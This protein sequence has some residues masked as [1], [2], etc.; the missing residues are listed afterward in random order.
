MSG[1]ATGRPHNPGYQATE[2]TGQ[3]QAACSRQAR[4]P[5][6][7][8][9]ACRQ[10]G[11][12]GFSRSMP[13]FPQNATGRVWECRIL[14]EKRH[15]A[16]S[17]SAPR[18]VFCCC[19]RDVVAFFTKDGIEWEKPGCV[20]TKSSVKVIAALLN[21]R[22]A[23]LRADS[24]IA[25][26]LPQAKKPD[27]GRLSGF[28]VKGGEKKGRFSRHRGFCSAREL[29]CWGIPLAPPKNCSV[30][31][32]PCATRELPCWKT[33]LFRKGAASPE[34]LP[35]PPESACSASGSGGSA[36]ATWPGGLPL[37]CRSAGRPPKRGARRRPCSAS[38]S[39]ARRS[40]RCGRPRRG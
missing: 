24:R 3:S 15:S 9:P 8:Q 4:L 28:G 29:L 26:R 16:G 10:S 22:A 14:G 11:L 6:G 5:A 37:P 20:A 17:N 12:P 33:I 31:D 7:S 39:R 18:L 1:R 40:R 32:L 34:F 19:A 23:N 2:R 36:S 27:D 21:C 25:F 35:A 30:G 38:C 13:S